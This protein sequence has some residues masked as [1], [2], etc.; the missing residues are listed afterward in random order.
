MAPAPRDGAKTASRK[1]SRVATATTRMN[2]Q[3]SLGW[4]PHPGANDYAS[5]QVRLI[6]RSI[7]ISLLPSS[8]CL[9]VHLLVIHPYFCPSSPHLNL[10][11]TLSPFHL[12]TL[13]SI[14]TFL[15][16]LFM[17]QSLNPLSIL[18]SSM[19]PT[20]HP[21]MNPQFII[22]HPSIIHDQSIFSSIHSPFYNPHIPS[23]SHPSVHYP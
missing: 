17:L 9:S 13:S 23:S 20:L 14:L 21:S 22:F 12:S 18:Q 5:L 11:I 6:R 8:T 16:H 19:H 10:P 4:V 7:Y 2:A 1:V 15:Y 3:E